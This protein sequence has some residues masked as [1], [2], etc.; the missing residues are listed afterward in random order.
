MLGK[1]DFFNTHR[2]SHLKP[3][4]S[5]PPTHARASPPARA[6]NLIL[7]CQLNYLSNPR[8]PDL[9]LVF[10]ASVYTPERVCPRT[11]YLLLRLLLR[12]NGR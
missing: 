5:S 10:V 1:M 4:A 7:Q 8:G 6:S 11:E 9:I 12:R 3:L 2:P